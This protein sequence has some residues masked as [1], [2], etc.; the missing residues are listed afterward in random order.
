MYNAIKIVI[1]AEC[2]G[3][4]IKSGNWRFVGYG[5]N[6]QSKYI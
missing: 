1:K 5:I 3:V 6:K 4:I 2:S